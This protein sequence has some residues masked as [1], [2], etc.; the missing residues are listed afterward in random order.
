M[1]QLKP[2][3]FCNGEANTYVQGYA[4]RVKIEVGCRVCG[5]WFTDFAIEGSSFNM[6]KESEEK[7]IA[8][9]N[10]RADNSGVKENDK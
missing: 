2:C 1:E 8:R 6:L 4:N 3:P 7:L 5:F 9:W 10:R